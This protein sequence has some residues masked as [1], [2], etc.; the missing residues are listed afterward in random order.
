MWSLEA[1][2]AVEWNLF[3]KKKIIVYFVV[4]DLLKVFTK[5]CIPVFLNLCNCYGICF[6]NRPFPIGPFP[7]F[8]NESSYDTI[9][10]KM[11]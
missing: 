6:I 2:L 1:G 10:M 5:Q 7:H 9:Q 4:V 8:Q 3:K 11:I